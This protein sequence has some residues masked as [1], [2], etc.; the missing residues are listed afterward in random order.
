MKKIFTLFAAVA[1]GFAAYAQ[2]ACP[3][4]LSFAPMAEEQD[5]N[6]VMIELQLVNSSLNLN[7]F[8]MEVGRYAVAEEILWLWP[9]YPCKM[10][11]RYRQQARATAL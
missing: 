2:E 3:S 6:K 10:G 7:G 5:A 11:R 1:L 8:N 4:V 9:H